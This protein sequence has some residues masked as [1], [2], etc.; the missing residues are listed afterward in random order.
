MNTLSTVS[1]ILGSLT[2]RASNLAPWAE[3]PVIKWSLECDNPEGDCAEHIFHCFIPRSVDPDG[4]TEATLRRNVSDSV[5]DTFAGKHHD[6]IAE[7]M[8]SAIKDSLSQDVRIERDEGDWEGTRA[9]FSLHGE[10]YHIRTTI[11]FWAE[12]WAQLPKNER[13]QGWLEALQPCAPCEVPPTA[14]SEHLPLEPEEQDPSGPAASDPKGSQSNGIQFEWPAI[15]PEGGIS[16]DSQNLF[17]SSLRSEKVRGP[18]DDD[19]S[20]RN[21]SL[22]SVAVRSADASDNPGEIRRSV[23]IKN[24]SSASRTLSISSDGFPGEEGT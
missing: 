7:R 21:P 8:E 23:R 22:T 24:C 6:K 18:S 3:K 17:R 11:P 13:L 4:R 10:T 20:S 1:Q 15:S 5:A 12:L 9:Y 19:S 2:R 16:K 14:S